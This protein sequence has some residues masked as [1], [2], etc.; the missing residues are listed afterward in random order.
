MINEK[1]ECQLI[2]APIL[3]VYPQL[4]AIYLAHT[5]FHEVKVRIRVHEYLRIF[6]GLA[7]KINTIKGYHHV[8]ETK[9][10]KFDV[11][12]FAFGWEMRE[13]RIKD[14]GGWRWSHDAISDF[15]NIEFIIY[16]VEGVFWTD[17]SATPVASVCVLRL[18]W[19]EGRE[20]D[21]MGLPFC[22]FSDLFWFCHFWKHVYYI[23]NWMHITIT[24]SAWPSGKP[25][26]LWVQGRGFKPWWKQNLLFITCFLN[27][28][29]QLHSLISHRKIDLFDSNFFTLLIYLLYFDIVQK[30]SK[31][32]FYFIYFY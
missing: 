3:N 31:K 19:P 12:I 23:F 8:R 29:S 18:S 9:T 20:F 17:V 11:W 6:S 21:P 25:F 2:S 10:S 14:D 27:F 24:T 32:C 16:L 15:Q 1:W 5:R 7:L 28:Y 22:F 26:H 13:I 30:N 4:I